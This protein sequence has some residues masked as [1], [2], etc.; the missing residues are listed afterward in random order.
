ML[1]SLVVALFVSWGCRTAA[2]PVP[3]P[4][5]EPPAVAEGPS[6]PEGHERSDEGVLAYGQAG[7]TRALSDLLPATYEDVYL[8]LGRLGKVRSA[9]GGE[10][11]ADGGGRPAERFGTP[12]LVLEVDDARSCAKIRTLEHWSWMTK[13]DGTPDPVHVGLV[14]FEIYVDLSDLDPV[15]TRFVRLAPS[16]TTVFADNVHGLWLAP[17]VRVTMG[18]IRDSR[19]K[20]TAELKRE[21]FT[22][23]VENDSLGKTF[24]HGSASCER[25]ARVRDTGATVWYSHDASPPIGDLRTEY[26]VCRLGG[27][28]S[29]VEVAQILD[30]DSLVWI[31]GYVEGSAITEPLPARDDGDVWGYMDEPAEASTPAPGMIPVPVGTPFYASSG[32]QIG[33]TR[34]AM[35]MRTGEAPGTVIVPTQWGNVEARLE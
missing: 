4:E 27:V 1:S 12:V 14:D 23:W 13:P 34:T 17:G 30:A 22:G 3:H 11:V 15:T 10:V 21:T 28:G 29:R 9:C 26:L 31:V 8:K 16:P 18:E 33:K 20:V 25:D 6:A 7:D 32:A 19:T 24:R 2:D 35:R 5:R